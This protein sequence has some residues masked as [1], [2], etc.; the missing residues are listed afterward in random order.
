MLTIALGIGLL[1]SV[2][3]TWV[4]QVQPILTKKIA[5]HGVKTVAEIVDFKAKPFHM[6]KIAYMMNIEYETPKGK[7]KRFYK[8][9]ITKDR[10]KNYQDR[11]GNFFTKGKKL[12]IS[13]LPER[14]DRF[15]VHH[16][17]EEEEKKRTQFMLLF[18]FVIIIIFPVIMMIITNFANN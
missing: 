18:G 11:Y 2:I 4:R 6:T 5:D 15:I 7:V 10:V 16:P 12:P 17:I 14:P 1:Y 8:K 3:N 13:Y 9:I